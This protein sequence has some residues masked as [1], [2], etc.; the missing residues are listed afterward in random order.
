M[1][2]KKKIVPVN[3][4]SVLDMTASRIALLC[5]YVTVILTMTVKTGIMR[6]YDY[7]ILQHYNCVLV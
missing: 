4:R 2:K 7:V 3:I 5:L 1:I 6:Q